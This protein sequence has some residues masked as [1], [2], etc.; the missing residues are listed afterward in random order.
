MGQQ[1]PRYGVQPPGRY[2]DHVAVSQVCTGLAEKHPLE[3]LAHPGQPVVSLRL[4][5]HD[6]S[7]RQASQ[8]EPGESN[9][10]SGLRRSYRP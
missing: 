6:W 1:A 10:A 2:D 9:L 4:R 8:H 5:G 7:I 3:R